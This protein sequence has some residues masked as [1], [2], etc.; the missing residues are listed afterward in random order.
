MLHTLRMFVINTLICSS[1]VPIQGRWRLLRLMGVDIT[2]AIVMSNVHFG[3]TNI[4]VGKDSGFNEQ[5]FL[6]TSAKITIGRQVGIGMRSL[7]V[8]S[9]HDMEGQQ[10]WGTQHA[11]P[12]HIDDFTW[13]GANVTV[14]PGVT[15]GKGCVIAAGS[16]VTKDCAPGGFYAGVPAS[17]KRDL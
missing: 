13:L 12:V 4:S 11:K 8:T 9:S 15:I 1:L 17:R 7:I 5:V 2:N 3:G 10:R 6:D 14:M 16:V